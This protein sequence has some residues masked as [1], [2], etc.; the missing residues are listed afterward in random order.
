MATTETTTQLPLSIE[1]SFWSGFIYKIKRVIREVK[2]SSF[3][4]VITHFLTWVNV[5]I[6]ALTGL[7]LFRN[8]ALISKGMGILFDPGSR[9][10][11]PLFREHAVQNLSLLPYVW[12]G[13]AGVLLFSVLTSM[14]VYTFGRY[15]I[16][17]FLLLITSILL[18]LMA[19]VIAFPIL[20]LGGF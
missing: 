20:L 19:K 1:V 13:M 8:T 14:L 4:L 17:T 3:V 18:L 11:I 2:Y 7:L 16:T 9:S 5:G 15:G 6:V 10:L 12:Y